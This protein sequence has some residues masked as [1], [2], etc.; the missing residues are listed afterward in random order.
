MSKINQ[1]NSSSSKLLHTSASPS[2]AKVSRDIDLEIKEK[3]FYKRNV[4]LLSQEDGVLIGT[5]KSDNILLSI[6]ER[7]T[8]QVTSVISGLN[9][10]TNG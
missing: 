10:I 8:V 3:G 9:D 1:Q 2:S 4:K 5:E 6:E 7:D